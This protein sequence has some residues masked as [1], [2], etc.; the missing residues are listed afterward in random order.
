MLAISRESSS[1]QLTGERSRQPSNPLARSSSAHITD[2]GVADT[3]GLEEVSRLPGRSTKRT[4]GPAKQLY[5][6]IEV[7][8]EFSHNVFSCSNEACMCSS[9]F[10]SKFACI[11]R[12]LQAASLLNTVE[13]PPSRKQ[14]DDLEA[15]MMTQVKESNV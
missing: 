10:L 8:N 9:F 5:R 11:V 14:I 6:K 15:H 3:G 2:R 7:F 13:R 12:C 4:T 1:R